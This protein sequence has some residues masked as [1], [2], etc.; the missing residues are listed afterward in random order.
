MDLAANIPDWAVFRLRTSTSAFSL[1]CLQV[2]GQMF[3]IDAQVG[4]VGKVI[5]M[6]H[7]KGFGVLKA[8]DRLASP[9][10]LS[11]PSS[12]LSLIRG[13]WNTVCAQK[14]TKTLPRKS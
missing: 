7:G 11:L 12:L 6:R 3:S 4:Q 2:L 13:F 5:L 8:T 10:W 1:D 9:Q 14:C